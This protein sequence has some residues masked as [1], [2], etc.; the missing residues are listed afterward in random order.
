M[1]AFDTLFSHKSEPAVQVLK[2]DIIKSDNKSNI[3]LFSMTNVLQ[4]VLQ[5][6]RLN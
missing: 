6:A 2:D 3:K 4:T 5:G 1:A